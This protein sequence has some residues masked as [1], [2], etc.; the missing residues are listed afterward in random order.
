[1]RNKCK[2]AT[3]SNVTVKCNHTN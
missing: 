1:M 2:A 3:T